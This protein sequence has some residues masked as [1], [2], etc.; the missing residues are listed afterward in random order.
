[1]QSVGRASRHL[2]I[3]VECLTRSLPPAVLQRMSRLS[4]TILG[5]AGAETIAA[6]DWPARR[7]FEGHAIRLAALI[8]GNL[9]LF[10][11]GSASLSRP[12]KVLAPRI[13]TRLTTL[14]MA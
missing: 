7:W 1:M 10:T 2:F 8:A 9:K 11:L 3:I 5:A 4:S 14:W 12:A 6:Q 13:A